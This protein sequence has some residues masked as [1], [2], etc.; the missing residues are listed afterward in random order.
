MI[1][2]T[3]R[4]IESELHDRAKLIAVT[5]TKPVELLREAYEAGCRRFGE[6]KVQE[7]AE[8]Q[9]QFPSDLEWHLIGHLQTNKVKYI[10]PFVAL[11]HSV[12]SL[13]LLQE[14]NKQA[15][16]CNRII[17][18]LLQIY[19]ADE[20]TKFGLSAQEAEA[21][22][23]APELDALP[24]VRIVGLM[25]LATNTDDTDKVR[26]EF[27]GLKQLYDRLGQIKRPMIQF[28]ELSMGMSGDYQIAVEE[29][30]T[31]VRVGS[32]IFGSRN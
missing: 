9:P 8:K 4:L 30:S 5:K 3:I 2:D 25:G 27:R 24:N 18:C 32:A 11:I 19:I 17:D 28:R 31:L 23:N 6:N 21:L 10:A 20:E 16:K 12:D 15:A 7:M 22:L 29:G 13:K 26:L 14:I 1:A